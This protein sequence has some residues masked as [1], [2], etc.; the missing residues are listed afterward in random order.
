MAEYIRNCANFQVRS[1]HIKSSSLNCV[2]LV[3][4]AF[5]ILS[6]DLN[7]CASG[8]GLVTLQFEYLRITAVA[9]NI[10]PRVQTV[11]SLFIVSMKMLFK[12]KAC[13]SIESMSLIVH[14]FVFGV[15]SLTKASWKS[16]C[17]STGEN[18]QRN[19]AQT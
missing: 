1:V 3:R 9:E 12:I 11:Y 8:K 17:C 10:T 13:D 19:D 6:L 2:H 15:C 18:W 4:P 16:S 14:S 5:F 7:T